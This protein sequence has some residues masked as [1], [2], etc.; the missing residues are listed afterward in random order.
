MRS[1]GSALDEGKTS[2][3]D[4]WGELLETVRYI[5][6]IMAMLEIWDHLSLPRVSVS[7]T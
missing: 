3:G 1:S 5:M 7:N 4:S 2:P 6:T